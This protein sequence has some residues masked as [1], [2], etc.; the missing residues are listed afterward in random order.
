MLFGQL[1]RSH[2]FL[3]ES[4]HLVM[5]GV[6]GQVN[7]KDPSVHPDPPYCEGTPQPST[8]QVHSLN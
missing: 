6:R 8:A 7:S 4:R 1:Y 3:T 5:R 2:H